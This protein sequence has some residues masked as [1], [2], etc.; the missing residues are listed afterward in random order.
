MITALTGKDWSAMLSI[1]LGFD[2]VE[3]EVP[4]WVGKTLNV[5]RILLPI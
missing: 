5:L 1:G 3:R 4:L 2:R